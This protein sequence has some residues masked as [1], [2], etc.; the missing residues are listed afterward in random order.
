[1]FN[2]RVVLNTAVFN[3]SRDNVATLFTNSLGQEA[4]AFD[5]QLTNGVEASLDAAITAQWHLLANATAQ[6][7]VVTDAPQALTTFG[8]HPQGVPAYMA[9]L[10][11]TYKFSIGGIAGFQVGAGANYRDKTYSDNTNVNS[12]PAYVIGNAMIGWDNANWG[13]ALNVKN[14][15]NE[16]YFIAANGAGGF[17]GEGLGAFVTVRYHQ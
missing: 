15:T 11:S 16:R 10:W 13:V 8:N 12:V 3:V 1:M 5:S 6:S 2:D 9:N 7:A 17:V 14:I 4:V